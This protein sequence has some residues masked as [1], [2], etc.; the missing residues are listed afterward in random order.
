MF[1]RSAPLEY[2]YKQDNIP[3]AIA[4]AI[5]ENEKQ[6]NRVHYNEIHRRIEQ[7]LDHPVSHRQ[8]GKYLSYMIIEKLLTREDPT[9][10]RGSKVHFSF[11]NLGKRK[12]RLRILGI[13]EAIE[14]RKTLYQLL[15]FF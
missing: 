11:T 6:N 12:Y 7:L 4:K 5:F 14:K 3:S 1:F 15:I 10:K 13:D 8:L 2:K 9:G